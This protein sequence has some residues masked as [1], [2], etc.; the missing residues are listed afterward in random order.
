MPTRFDGKS[1]TRLALIGALVGLGLLRGLVFVLQQDEQPRTVQVATVQDRPAPTPTPARPRTEVAPRPTS[2]PPAADLG[3]KREVATKPRPSKT[4][5]Q[6]PTVE[7]ASSPDDPM[8]PVIARLSAV[9]DRE[10]PD[11]TWAAKAQ[12]RID[13]YVATAIAVPSD[14]TASCRSTLCRITMR[15]ADDLGRDEALGAVSLPW[16]GEGV[17]RTD[18]DDPLKVVLYAAREGHPLPGE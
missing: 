2:G 9:H 12:L 17:F 4:S 14:V 11:P 16:D 1:L 13:E 15:F 8:A 18:P 6:A 3:E 7:G 5:A 10:V